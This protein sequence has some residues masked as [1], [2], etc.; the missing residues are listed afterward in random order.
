[1]EKCPVCGISRDGEIDDSTITHETEKKKKTLGGEQASLR[2][3]EDQS[4][5]RRGGAKT[6]SVY[7][8]Y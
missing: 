1:M 4:A 6:C 7:Y 3:A 5:R 2:D 8:L